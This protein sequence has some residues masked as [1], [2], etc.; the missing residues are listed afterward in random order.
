[1]YIPLQVLLILWFDP[2]LSSEHTL[3]INESISQHSITEG[4]WL[5]YSGLPTSGL[6]G[7]DD[8]LVDAAAAF[9]K[10]SVTNVSANHVAM[11]SL[12]L[13]ARLSAENFGS[14]ELKK[15]N[16]SSFGSRKLGMAL[17]LIFL[18][19]LLTVGL[20]RQAAAAPPDLAAAEKPGKEEMLTVLKKSEDKRIAEAIDRLEKVK[21][22]LPAASRL[23]SAV[24]S[25][26]SKKLMAEMQ[27]G[28][29]KASEVITDRKQLESCVDGAL[30]T[31][32][33]LQRTAIEKAVII[34]Q[35]DSSLLGCSS[36]RPLVE[37]IATFSSEGEYEVMRSYIRTFESF[38]ETDLCLSQRCNEIANWIS[39]Q[40]PFKNETHK[41]RLLAIAFAV[42][43]LQEISAFRRHLALMGNEMSEGAVSAVRGLLLEE[44]R[45]VMR[46]IEGCKEVLK[47][48]AFL[49]RNNFKETPLE[50][51]DEKTLSFVER[52]LEGVDDLINQLLPY[53]G[54]METS[55][56]LEALFAADRKAAVL[57][58]KAQELIM[59]CSAA[60]SSLP[61][62]SG[63]IDRAGSKLMVDAAENVS[64]RML[65]DH[66]EMLYV[67]QET[68]EMLKKNRVEELSG[69]PQHMNA[70]LK[71]KLTE[72]ATELELSA[73][74]RVRNHTYLLPTLKST[75]GAPSALGLLKHA[76]ISMLVQSDDKGTAHLLNLE[77][78]LLMF[79]EKDLSA[80]VN[81]ISRTPSKGFFLS[82]AERLMYEKAQRQFKA[83]RQAV[84]NASTVVEAA[85]AAAKLRIEALEIQALLF[86]LEEKAKNFECCCG[87]I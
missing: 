11:D 34:V 41:K 49:Q 50:A 9:L 69:V 21:G 54:K 82:P 2:C 73:E 86:S 76:Y 1:M 77:A 83:S 39:T 66:D 23:A 14:S 63:K 44:K 16:H 15:E 67:L 56:T 71:T 8:I 70:A 27:E 22:L 68:R 46:E 18:V 61:A 48:R 25:E 53:V 17:A 30:K 42:E 78:R 40:K 29:R 84:K 74:E 28:I 32:Q 6:E 72:R 26:E 3:A 24:D 31:L 85:Q 51:V 7:T 36:L 12:K 35:G 45:T 33:K 13:S 55:I 19:G 81:E 5:S 57:E 37:T 47:M 52:S 60:A 43:R 75:D 4:A 79:L 38:C 65:S 58:G 20:K 10:S 64:E 80:T 62:V 59:K 87:E